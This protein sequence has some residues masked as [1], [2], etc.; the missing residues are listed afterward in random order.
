MHSQVLIKRTQRESAV[1]RLT[2]GLRRLEVHLRQREWTITL[3]KHR[4]ITLSVVLSTCM[5]LLGT[6]SIGSQ[7]SRNGSEEQKFLRAQCR[8]KRW[9]TDSEVSCTAEMTRFTKCMFCVVANRDE[10]DRGQLQ[11][12]L[13]KEIH[14]L[15]CSIEESLC[16]LDDSLRVW[17][18]NLDWGEDSCKL[19][20]G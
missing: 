17:H 5:H 18:C 9:V 3:G 4:V 12:A 7:K 11:A 15:R 6:D 8:R 1:T 2:L 13:L 19:Q 14:D 10:R 20:W 16:T